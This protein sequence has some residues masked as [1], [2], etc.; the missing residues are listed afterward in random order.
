[1]ANGDPK[2]LMPAAKGDVQSELNV[3]QGQWKQARAA[4]Q[5][6]L[7]AHDQIMAANQAATAINQSMPGL[8]Q[9]WNDLTS[10]LAKSTGGRNTLVYAAKQAYYGQL[11]QRD[12]N[13][14][15]TG[16]HG[17]T[18]FVSKELP[19]AIQ[20]FTRI[21]RAMLD[22]DSQLGITAITDTGLLATLRTINEQSIK[23]NGSLNSM[24]S[25]LKAL[26][27]V[28]A[29]NQT[30]HGLSS[31]MLVTTRAIDTSYQQQISNRLYRPIIAYVFGAIGLLLLLMILWIYV[32]GGDA[33]RS[34]NLQRDQNERNQQAICGCWMSL[35]H[36]PTAILRCRR[37]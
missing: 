30:L 15:V 22:G 37:R 7:G 14:L 26:A 2:T 20:N 4:V 11:I 35:V 27:A 36:W 31:Q 33:R 29:A 28:Q 13:L 19:D 23:L 12:V 10:Q 3:L 32:I 5:T 21:T 16:G 34:V 1:M 25:N 24:P 6:I 8:I 17:D 18:G 9:S